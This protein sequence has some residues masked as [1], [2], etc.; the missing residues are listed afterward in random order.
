MPRA[1]QQHSEFDLH[2]RGKPWEAHG[3]LGA[4]YITRGLSVQPGASSFS[5]QDGF[6]GLEQR[7]SRRSRGKTSWK[8]KVWEGRRNKM[9]LLVCM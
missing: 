1:C 9:W 8:S 4:Q 2:D 3:D 7:A 6:A 5:E